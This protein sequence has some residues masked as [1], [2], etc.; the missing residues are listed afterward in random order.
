MENNLPV[1]AERA[2][3][4]PLSEKEVQIAMVIYN[5]SHLRPYPL[6]DSQIEDW[7][8]VINRL[9]PDLDLYDL[10][11]MIDKMIIGEIEY[12]NKEGIQNIFRGLDNYRRGGMVY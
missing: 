8:K 4:T 11:G 2:L 5:I 6:S 9:L 1:Q 3:S 10:S 7:S 12:D